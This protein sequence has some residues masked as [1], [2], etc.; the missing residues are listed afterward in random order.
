MKT[1]CHLNHTVLLSP[2]TAQPPVVVDCGSNQ[3]EFAQWV[4]AQFGARVIGFEP[5]PRLF[6]KLPQIEGVE[7]VRKA[8]GAKAEQAELFLG[9]GQC[10]SLRFPDASGKTELVEIT[11]LADEFTQRGLDRVDLLKLDIEGAE[12]DVLEST[13]ADVLQ[14]CRQITVEFHDFMNKDDVPRIKQCIKRMEKIGFAALKFSTLTF[15]DIL[16]VNQRSLP[17]SAIQQLNA[18]VVGKLIPG[19]A[20]KFSQLIGT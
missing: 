10:S 17:L 18:I 20:R 16:F 12:L 11:T 14:K 7:F 9:D 13:P 3:G 4:V 19:F 1:I 8:V 2:L 15:G 5:D 6:A